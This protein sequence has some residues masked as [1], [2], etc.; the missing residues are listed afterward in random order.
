M[1]IKLIRK[2]AKAPTRG[3]VEAAELDLYAAKT[4]AVKAGHI[5]AVPLGFEMSLP[6]GKVALVWPRSG[7]ALK[8]GLSVPFKHQ[9]IETRDIDAGVVD[10]DYRGECMVVIVNRSDSDYTIS[11]GERFAQMLV[12]DVWLG[13][14][15]ITEELDETGRGDGGFGSTGR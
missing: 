10:S 15:E 1:K 8:Y 11:Q 14:P 13:E 4:T 12:Q 5:V 7:H 6:L 3:S 9:I 2:G